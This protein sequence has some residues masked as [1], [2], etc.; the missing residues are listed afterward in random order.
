MTQVQVMMFPYF[1]FPFMNIAVTGSIFMTVAIA[2]ER[3]WAVH[4]PID[5]S[6]AINSPEACKKR[7]FKYVVPVLSFSSAVNLPKFFESYVEAVKHEIVPDGYKL[8]PDDT[9]RVNGTL[10]ENLTRADLPY[11]YEYYIEVTDF[12]KNTYYTIYYTNWTR[13]L[14]MGI[15]PTVLLIYFNYKIYKDV[16]HRNRRQLSMS[17]TSAT[18]TQQARRKQEDNL[19][20]VFMGIVL[21]FLVCNF[22]RNMLS[23][24]ESLWIRRSMACQKTGMRGFP[25][26]A[27]IL[28]NFSHL[29]LVVNSSTNM[30]LYI[31]LNK[32]FRMHFMNLVKKI[33]DCVC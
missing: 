15:I 16:K 20:V 24:F 8:W 33:V 32:Q 4:Y 2:F 30:I 18:A 31:F 28:G 21:I 3:Y 12:R 29:L 19:A 1:I 14:I 6:Q 10:I 22:P 7:L 23:L 13:L 27:I 26:W 11:E 5:Y 25:V 17:R 9:V